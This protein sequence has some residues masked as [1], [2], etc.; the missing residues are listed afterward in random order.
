MKSWRDGN[1]KFTITALYIQK[2]SLQKFFFFTGNIEKYRPLPYGIGIFKEN[3]MKK[4]G[5]NFSG[6]WYLDRESKQR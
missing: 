4:S 1:Q 5:R 2:I 6:S 3:C